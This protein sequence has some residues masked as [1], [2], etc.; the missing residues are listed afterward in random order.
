MCFFISAEKAYLEGQ[1]PIY[2]LETLSSRNNS[3]QKLSKFSQGI[4]MLGVAHS[5]IEGFLRTDT[6]ASST[7]K[8]TPKWKKKRAY[9]SLGKPKLQEVFLSKTLTILTGNQCPRYSC[10]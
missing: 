9:V 10:F 1:Y 2:P 7:E 6:C 5:N 4:N 8:N 3:F